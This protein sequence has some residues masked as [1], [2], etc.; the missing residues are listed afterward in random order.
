M[1][2]G[3]SV[4]AKGQLEA[5]RRARHTNLRRFNRQVFGEEGPQLSLRELVELEM[6]TQREI[7]IQAG[8][9]GRTPGGH[10]S[11]KM[12]T[13]ASEKWAAAIDAVS[14][15]KT[16]SGPLPSPRPDAAAAAA[17][18]PRRLSP[19]ILSPFLAALGRPRRR[20]ARGADRRG[21]DSAVLGSGGDED[22]VDR[23]RPPGRGGA[24]GKEGEARAC[25]AAGEGRVDALQR[26]NL[27][28]IRLGM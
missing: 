16:A 6:K 20:R 28:S 14:S 12:A 21:D 27:G 7:E 9:S 18:S 3:S 11:S 22:A 8:E 26:A 25:G 1:P 10:K 2:V 13:S 19:P 17:P 24:A 5:P 15:R 4:L 23:T